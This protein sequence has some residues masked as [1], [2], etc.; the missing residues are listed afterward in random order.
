M[1]FLYNTVWTQKEHVNIFVANISVNCLKN[2]LPCMIRRKILGSLTCTY[3][4]LL[5]TDN[6]DKHISVNFL[7]FS[8]SWTN[9]VYSIVLNKSINI[10]TDCI[11]YWIRILRAGSSV[12]SVEIRLPKKISVYIFILISSQALS[13]VFWKFKIWPPVHSDAYFGLKHIAGI[14]LSSY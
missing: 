8:L 5:D 14:L 3:Y 10:Y 1:Q 2:S 9:Y 12:I 7:L 6:M 13:K 11:S 4:M